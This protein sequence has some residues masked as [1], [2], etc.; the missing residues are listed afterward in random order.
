MAKGLPKFYD[1]DVPISSFMTKRLIGI[2]RGST[3]QQAAQRMGEFNISSLVVV[4][5]G[6]VVGFFTESDLREKV[7]AKGLTPEVKVEEIMIEDLITVEVDTSVEKA[8]GL[9][10]DHNIKHLL[11]KEKGEVVGILTFRDLIDVERQRIETHI[12]R[13]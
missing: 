13:D 9:M 7:V 6:E 2:E 1:M 8:V 4:R 3:V 12:S 10:A 5:E 11:V